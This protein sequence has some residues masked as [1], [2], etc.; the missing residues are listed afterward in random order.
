MTFDAIRIFQISQPHPEMANTTASTTSPNPQ[1][2]FPAF[3]ECQRHLSHLAPNL[4]VEYHYECPYTAT[5]VLLWTISNLFL[6]FCMVKAIYDFYNLPEHKKTRAILHAAL[7]LLY[8]TIPCSLN[9]HGV[10]MSKSPGSDHV[11]YLLERYF[12][13][14]WYGMVWI[15]CWA[16]REDS[17][18]R[19]LV[20]LERRLRG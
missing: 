1:M 3:L 4:I 8:V 19:Y 11:V 5:Y 6:R 17:I 2:I 16:A 14:M 7:L 20:L 9:E 12:A 18:N 13:V 15:A 10:H